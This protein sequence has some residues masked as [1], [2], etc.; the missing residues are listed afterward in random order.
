MAEPRLGVPQHLAEL[1]ELAYPFI[2]RGH[3]KD[4][5]FC[6]PGGVRVIWSRCTEQHRQEGALD[7]FAKNVARVHRLR[8][9][10]H[11]RACLAEDSF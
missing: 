9:S 6:L 5:K 3:A 7:G 2:K 1:T 8:Q 4:Q 11:S 10:P